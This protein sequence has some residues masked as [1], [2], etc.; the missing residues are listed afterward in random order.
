M[1]KENKNMSAKLD[2]TVEVVNDEWAS[3]EMIERVRSRKGN[4]MMSIVIDGQKCEVKR[5]VEEK[6]DHDTRSN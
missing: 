3:K 1:G 2:E 6:S 4:T 5:V